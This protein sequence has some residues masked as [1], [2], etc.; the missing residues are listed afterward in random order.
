MVARSSFLFETLK[1][2]TFVPITIIIKLTSNPESDLGFVQGGP[3][4]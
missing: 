1:E 2:T 3:E 4:L